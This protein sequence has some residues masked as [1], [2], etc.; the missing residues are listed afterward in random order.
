MIKILSSAEQEAPP[1]KIFTKKFSKV[2]QMMG[3]EYFTPSVMRILFKMLRIM[4]NEVRKSRLANG[5][6]FETEIP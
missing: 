5:L 4:L 2:I 1:T 6:Y 3:I